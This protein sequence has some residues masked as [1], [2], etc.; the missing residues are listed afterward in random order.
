MLESVLAAVLLL[1][2]TFEVAGF[3]PRFD[4]K[5]AII[6][7]IAAHRMRFRDDWMSDCGTPEKQRTGCL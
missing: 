3:D 5:N 2:T 4:W 1:T 6:C 7:K